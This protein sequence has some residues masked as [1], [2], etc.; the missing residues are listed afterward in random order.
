MKTYLT[1]DDIL[2]IKIV[3]YLLEAVADSKYWDPKSQY[4]VPI[5]VRRIY[6]RSQRDKP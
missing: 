2:I 3:S 6:E 4:M 1:S 5:A